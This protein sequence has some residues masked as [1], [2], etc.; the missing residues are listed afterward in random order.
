MLS[1]PRTC[2]DLPDRT[3]GSKNRLFYSLPHSLLAI[4][5][6]IQ[7]HTIMVSDQL[8]GLEHQQALGSL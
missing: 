8:N 2:F 5:L 6:I 4:I 3:V 1:F 7:T